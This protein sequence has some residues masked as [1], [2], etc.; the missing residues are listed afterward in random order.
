VFA[1]GDDTD[2]A[3]RNH[4]PALRSGWQGFFVSSFSY[5]QFILKVGFEDD[6]FDEDNFS[7]TFAALVRIYLRRL[8]PR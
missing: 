7:S 6:A 5:G 1:G 4:G 3:G 8:R 2:G